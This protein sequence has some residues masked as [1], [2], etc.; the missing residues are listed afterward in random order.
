[1]KSIL[2]KFF[3]FLLCVAMVLSLNTYNV[4]YA[5]VEA[6]T[7]EEVQ[8]EIDEYM[9]LLGDLKDELAVIGGNIEDLET[10]SGQNTALLEQYQA[11]IDALTVEAEINAIM[12]ESYDMK[13]AEV[14]AEKAMVQEDYDYRVSMYKRLMQ[15]IYENGET[16]SFELLFSSKNISDYLTRR[17][18]F[19]D[20]MNAAN[21]LIKEIDV[22]ISD[23]ELLDA[24][25]ATAQA[26]YEEY[27]SEVNQSKI[28]LE[29]KVKELNT[30]ASELNLDIDSITEQYSNK[31]S[32][33]KEINAKLATLKEEKAKLEEEER[34][35]REE[36]RKKR[37]EEERRKQEEA[38]KNNQNS[39]PPV[40]TPSAPS[41]S[42]FVWPVSA[43]YYVITSQYGNRPN[44]FGT[45]GYEFHNGLD[46]A[47]GR[48][49]PILAAKDGVVTRASWFSGYGN[50]VIIYHG[51][52]IS[53]LYGH[54]DNGNGSRPTFEVK[55]GDTVKAG[56]VIA[57]VGTTGRS[58]GYHL[59]Y[60]MMT[61][62][63]STAFSGVYIDPDLY[64]PD[65]FYNKN[66]A[67][68]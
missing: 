48:G 30:I 34:K 23:L 28:N 54:C 60:G 44:P 46:I 64:L 32:K 1:M 27:L 29:A 35:R 42:G 15:F 55:V 20:I 50:C 5:P 52:G 45:G 43:S 25:L 41:M 16:N 67:N 47:C 14:I 2:K 22:S 7:I 33:I 40:I 57:Y 36:E 68:T 18:N 66:A 53:S 13:R 10:Q 9:E 11:E 17:D 3:V 61:N 31:N 26:N 59:H 39:K 56:D 21:Q 4:D 62:T 63:E 58:T 37:E 8:D 19:N 51:N 12:L 6:R 49:T 65:G 38:N 24:E